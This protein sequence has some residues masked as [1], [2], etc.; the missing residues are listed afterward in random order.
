MAASEMTVPT[1]VEAL[2]SDELV[3]R[4]HAG[5]EEAFAELHDRYRPRLLTILHSRLGGQGHEADDLAQEA[6]LRALR[7]F[8]RFDQRYR[9]STWLYTIAIRLMHDFTR[10][11]R[12]RP[13]QRPLGEGDDP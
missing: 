13:K 1:D 6:F 9:F 5:S 7:H 12:R 8:D 2:D 11:Q 3:R 10:A 4:A